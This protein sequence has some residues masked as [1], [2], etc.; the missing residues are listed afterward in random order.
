MGAAGH[1]GSPQP[2]PQG[3]RIVQAAPRQSASSPTP[4]SRSPDKTCTPPTTQNT[5]LRPQA[6]APRASPGPGPAQPSFSSSVQVRKAS[7]TSATRKPRANTS[8]LRPLPPPWVNCGP[9]NRNNGGGEVGE[10]GSA[11]VRLDAR[12]KDHSAAQRS[13]AGGSMEGRGQVRVCTGAT[14]TQADATVCASSSTLSPAEGARGAPGHCRGAQ[15][16]ARTHP[17]Q[18]ATDVVRART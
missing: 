5:T 6:Q 3:R 2:S 9:A 16:R 15:V 8:L 12:R 1:I 7:H 11:A 14:G 10:G 17:P 4:T 18:I 13:T